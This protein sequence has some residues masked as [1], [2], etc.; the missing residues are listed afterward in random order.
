MDGRCCA[1]SHP[2]EPGPA[3]VPD[4]TS[5]RPAHRGERTA[6]ARPLPLPND[7]MGLAMKPPR[8]LYCDP[9][10][11]EDALA[12]KAEHGFD[13]LVLAGGPDQSGASRSR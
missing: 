9:E 5:A 4:S 13:A 3:Y 12:L 7:S 6:P 1:R 11:L 10:T 8:F 2:R